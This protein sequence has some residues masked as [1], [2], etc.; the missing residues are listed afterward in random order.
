MISGTAG[1]AGLPWHIGLNA[2]PEDPTEPYFVAHNY[3][4]AYLN[5][6]IGYT[7]VQPLVTPAQTAGHFT[8]GTIILF[9]RLE[10]ETVTMVTLPHHFAL[11]LQEGQLVLSV[12]GFDTVSLL[13]GDVAFVPAET[14]FSFHATIPFTKFLRT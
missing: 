10:N 6:E 2:L 1:D 13:Q 14:S 4:P 11:E 8:M 5:T 3:G 9:P 12:D 7:V